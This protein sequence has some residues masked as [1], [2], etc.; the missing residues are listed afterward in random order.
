MKNSFASAKKSAFA[1][2]RSSTKRGRGRR[3]NIGK[4]DEKQRKRKE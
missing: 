4:W 3:E 1:A 2:K